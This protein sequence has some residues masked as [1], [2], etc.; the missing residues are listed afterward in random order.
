MQVAVAGNEL[1][2]Q[3][4]PHDMEVAGTELGTHFYL[5]T[6]DLTMDVAGSE[7]GKQVYLM[8]WDWWEFQDSTLSFIFNSIEIVKLNGIDVAET[9]SMFFLAEIF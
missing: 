5:M 2:K 8:T 9:F 1:G 6:R 7:M 3:F 4:L